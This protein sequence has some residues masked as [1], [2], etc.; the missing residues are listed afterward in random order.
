MRDARRR[1]A[2]AIAVRAGDKAHIYADRIIMAEDANSLKETLY[3]IFRELGIRERETLL[4]V[5]DIDE[6][7]W[8]TVKVDLAVGILAQGGGGGE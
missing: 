3:H 2:R 6:E 1:I 4:L 7:E 5:R 8:E